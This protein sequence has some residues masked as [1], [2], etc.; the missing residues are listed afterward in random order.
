MVKVVK[1]T[2]K[3]ATET[4]HADGVEIPGR[5]GGIFGT[6]ALGFLI[7]GFVIDEMIIMRNVGSDVTGIPLSDSLEIT[8]GTW[9][10]CWKVPVRI[11]NNEKYNV[12]FDYD[13][14]VN[15]TK[16]NVSETI[17]FDGPVND[18]SHF[19][20]SSMTV[21]S[22]AWPITN[23]TTNSRTTLTTSTSS[24]SVSR[25]STSESISH[26][27]SY[28][29]TNTTSST[30]VSIS[31]TTSTVSAGRTEVTEVVEDSSVKNMC[32]RSFKHSCWLRVVAKVFNG[33]AICAGFFGDIF[34]EKVHAMRWA[35]VAM[36]WLSILSLA[37]MLLFPLGGSNSDFRLGLSFY[38]VAIATAC[39]FL[40]YQL[41][42]FDLEWFPNTR[43]FGLQNDGQ[44]MCS[45]LGAI[46]GF[47]TW[48]LL[49]LAVLSPAWSVTD[50]LGDNPNADNASAVPVN[51]Y[52][53]LQLGST[54]TA[55]WGILQYCLE[56]PIHTFGD[57]YG[58]VCL[59]YDDNLTIVGGTNSDGVKTLTHGTGC[60][61]FDSSPDY[62]LCS[63]RVGV[64]ISIGLGIVAAVLGD[65]FS[66][67]AAINIAVFT[68]AMG[69]ALGAMSL[70]LSFQDGISGPT[71]Y[72]A[73]SSVQYGMGLIFITFGSIVAV[74]T[75]V[76]YVLDYKGV[77]LP[78]YKPHA[79]G[80]DGDDDDDNYEDDDVDVNIE[81]RLFD[82]NTCLEFMCYGD[83]LG[84]VVAL[85][86]EEDVQQTAE[87]EA[88]AVPV[89]DTGERTEEDLTRVTE[90][91]DLNTNEVTDEAI[92]ETTA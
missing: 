56:L 84:P 67:K 87:A 7:M 5:I 9:R 78:V 51:R 19:T 10:A 4:V 73:Q 2:A 31:D 64:S 33:L 48:A 55:T 18:S 8:L 86:V 1:A 50:Y 75:V 17:V 3:S 83:D 28:N 61:L 88:A 38:L 79:Q 13:E 14:A 6:I 92:Q 23:A 41:C 39:A 40:A 76:F 53:D 15:V 37:C 29:V 49:L 90:E 16:W 22:T 69:G 34:S 63:T 62:N 71:E 44:G 91:S 25:S 35:G 24:I 46:F 36:V 66:E 21:S 58:L 89:A 74:C 27:T 42:K 68:V 57:R 82:C 26:S 32:Q 11:L 47:F 80:G 81:Y 12:C 65:I 54:H 85:D 30:P 45:R 59:N 72:G 43:R 52:R 20:S 77:C 60:D 70:W